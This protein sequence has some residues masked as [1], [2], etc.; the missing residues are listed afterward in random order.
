M[1]ERTVRPADHFA[2]PAVFGKGNDTDVCV[3]C[4]EPIHLHANPDGHKVWVHTG[5]VK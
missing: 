1:N 3:E 5:A 4:D 2:R